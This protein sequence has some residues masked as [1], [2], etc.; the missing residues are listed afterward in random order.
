MLGDCQ[1]S[2]HWDIGLL[3]Q[4]KRDNF[5]LEQRSICCTVAVKPGIK[6]RKSNTL[7]VFQP[8][9]AG[10]QSTA[11]F[12]VVLHSYTV[13][14]TGHMTDMAACFMPQIQFD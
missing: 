13:S 10:E 1:L 2:V 9:F 8:G 6:K 14:H 12:V 5:P 7:T 11:K 3:K 4:A